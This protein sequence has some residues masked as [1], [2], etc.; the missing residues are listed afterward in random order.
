MVGLG[1][2]PTGGESW[3]QVADLGAAPKSRQL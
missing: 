1:L 3:Y 2:Q